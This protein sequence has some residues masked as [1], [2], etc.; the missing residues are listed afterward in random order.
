MRHFWKGD[1]GFV[2]ELASRLAGSSDIYEP[3]GRGSYASVNFVTAHDGYTLYDLVSYEQKH[4]QANGED[5]RDGHN[6]NISR[7][8]GTEG[9]TDRRERSRDAHFALMR[10]F[11]ATLVF[12][13]GVPML[14]HGDEIARTQGGNNNA[15]A[16][17]N[18]ITW[19][20]WNITDRQKQLL[21]FTRK[22]FNLRH[23]HPVLR[24]RHF[25]R[26]E[27]TIKGGPKDLV[28]LRPDG[29]EMSN[30]DWHNYENHTVGMLI[31]GE[32]TDETDDRGRPIKGETLLLIVNALAGE[33]NF[34]L[35][36]IEGDGIWAE[37]IDTAH[38]E[39]RVVKTG[40]V[41][42]DAFSLTLLRYGENR[43]M[44]KNG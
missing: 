31:Y 25:F 38:R 30:G 32:A 42:V 21:A 20:D 43:R 13:Q 24:R 8:W 5:N 1:S 17:D 10:D 44:T 28:W 23:T 22:C 41:D 29:Q 40:N 33:V 18:E 16:Q 2:P 9:D 36:V 34:K 35:P 7:N 19:M 37:M 15:Y 27:A 3:S 4:N 14:S 11:I 39:L 12:S 6:D 26:G